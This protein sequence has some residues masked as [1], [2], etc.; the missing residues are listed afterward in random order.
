[1]SVWRRKPI[2]LILAESSD[3][4]KAA[5]SRTMSMYDLIALGV[6]AI[7]GTGIFVLTGVA[8]AKY[9]G[10]GVIVSFIIAG[11]AAGLAALVYAELA[12]LVPVAGSAYTYAYASLGEILAWI[13]GWNLVLEYVVAAGAVSIGWGSYFVD[14]LKSFRVILPDSFSRSPLEGGVINLPPIMITFLM[15]WIATRGTRHSA[16][17]T[18]SIV[19]I[20]LLV[21]LVFIIWGATRVNPSNWIPFAPFGIGG[22]MRG[23]AIVFFAYIG[24]DAVSTAA[25]E[26]KNPARDLPRGIIGSLAISTILYI[27]VA[28]VLTGMLSYTRL[29]TSSPVSAA[30]LA[31]GIRGASAFL[32]VGALAGLTSVLLA[33]IYAQSR[34][35]FAMARDGLLPP[36]F[37]VIHKKY[38]TPYIDTLLVGLVVALLGGF[39]PIGMV[40]ELANIGTLS[41]FL[42]VS[43]G[44]IVLRKTMPDLP[45]PFKVP[46]MPVVPLAAIGFAVFLI[47]NLPRL[48]WIRFFIWM[49][50]GL[51]IYFSYGYR[52]SRLATIEEQRAT[53][54]LENLVP[55]PARKPD[56]EDR[57]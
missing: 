46:W 53:V 41:A 31:A 54:V 20:K 50:L 14:L 24:F 6:G 49:A 43:I 35:F 22:I 25:E 48:T 7:I 2:N 38:K 11:T 12:S 23:A 52:R 56:Q 32:A 29:N 45:R 55:S 8:A 27:L 51:I 15:T 26:V 47:F 17:A 42:V 44:V 19:A 36:V 21:I 10:P 5:L 3:E 13:I 37:A 16:Q 1:M 57:E 9:A 39:L 33:C 40:A 34:I 30:F 18:K 4:G 28:A